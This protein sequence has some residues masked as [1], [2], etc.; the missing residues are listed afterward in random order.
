M[1]AFCVWGRI[2]SLCPG[3]FLAVVTALPLRGPVD[4]VDSSLV[5]LRRARSVEEGRTE[6]DAL[7]TEIDT[8][9]RE[10]GDHVAAVE[11]D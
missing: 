2:E 11:I 1:A 7:V 4:A 10:R 5:L 8:R 9:I 3:W 6:L